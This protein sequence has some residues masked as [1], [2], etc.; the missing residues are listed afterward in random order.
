M[1]ITFK[2]LSSEASVLTGY[3]DAD[4]GSDKVDRRSTSGF[5]FFY[6]GG[7]I[8]WKTRKQATV[9]ISTVEA[10]Y[11]ASTDTAKQA[12]HHRTLLTELGAMDGNTPT[13][14]RSDNQGCIA[15][16]EN[17]CHHGRTK[18]L[19]IR[20]HFI[21]EKVEDGLIALKYLSTGEMI[22]DMMTKAL[23]KPAFCKFREAVCS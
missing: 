1:G 5:L 14:I 19:D 2:G 22:A 10:E 6:G 13:I 16:T 3:G 17:P 11:L 7:P 20:H 12:L 23:P 15:L 18:H 9:A 8:S 21:R 4:W